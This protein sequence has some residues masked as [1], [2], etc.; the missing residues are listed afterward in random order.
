MVRNEISDEELIARYEQA[1]RG[2][3]RSGRVYLKRLLRTLDEFR[4]LP[5]NW[6]SY[7]GDRIAD[8]AID[9]A[10]NLIA[11][12]VLHPIPPAFLDTYSLDVMPLASGGVQLELESGDHYL[13][14]EISPDGSLSFLDVTRRGGER[15]AATRRLATADELLSTIQTSIY[16]Q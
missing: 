8:N 10:R 16:R 2:N 5:D 4:S 14:V 7:G 15:T 6:D 1:S 12:I 13:E 11:R 9:I 3:L